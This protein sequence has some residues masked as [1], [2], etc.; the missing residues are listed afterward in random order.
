MLIMGHLHVP[1]KVVV[2]ALDIA[3]RQVRVNR[4]PIQGLVVVCNSGINNFQKGSV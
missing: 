2:I 3:N 1:R 4:S